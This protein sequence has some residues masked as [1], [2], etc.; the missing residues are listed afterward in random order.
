MSRYTVARLLG[1]RRKMCHSG[2]RFC[3]TAVTDVCCGA[4]WPRKSKYIMLRCSLCSHIQWNVVA[5]MLI[6]GSSTGVRQ[7]YTVGYISERLHKRGWLLS[8]VGHQ[9]QWAIPVNK[10]PHAEGPSA[11]QSLQQSAG[12]AAAQK[13]TASVQPGG[14]LRACLALSGP[15]AAGKD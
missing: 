1:L 14:L 6:R 7:L 13:P 2:Q 10:I 15:P 8:D 3:C 12:C 5:A 9:Q 4:T 11:W